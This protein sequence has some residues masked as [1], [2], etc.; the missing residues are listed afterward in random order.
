MLKHKNTD[1][2]FHSII[3]CKRLIKNTHSNRWGPVFAT[4]LVHDVQGSSEA[5]VALAIAGGHLQGVAEF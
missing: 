2:Q 5:G 1:K 3:C 4:Y